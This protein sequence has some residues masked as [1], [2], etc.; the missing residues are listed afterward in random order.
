MWRKQDF[1]AAHAEYINSVAGTQGG[2]A[3]EQAASAKSLL[4]FGAIAQNQSDG[5]KAKTLACAVRVP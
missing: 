5:L 1:Q 3:A 2:S 4:D